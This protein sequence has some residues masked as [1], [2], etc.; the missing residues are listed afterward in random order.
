MFEQMPIP[1]DEYT[2]VILLKICTQLSDPQSFEFSRSLWKKISVNDRKNPVISTSFLHMLL[3]HEEI[4]ICEQFF[5]HIAKD[6]VTFTVMMKGKN[7][8]VLNCKIILFLQGY[9]EHQMPQKA[10]DLFFRIDKPNET[11]AILFFNACAELKDEKTLILA[12]KIFSQ[13]PRRF[14]QSRLLLETIFNTFCRCNDISTA[15][16]LFEQIHRDVIAYGSLMKTYNNQDQSEKTLQLFERMKHE[17]IRAN[18]IIDV[19]VINACANIRFLSLSQSIVRQIPHHLLNNRWIQ[20][21]LIDMWECL[22]SIHND[23][24]VVNLFRVN[25]VHYKKQS[26]FSIRSINQTVSLS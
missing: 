21:S 25:Q 11:N 15:E 4:S 13:L 19:L 3:K 26:E 10:I 17:N 7:F 8:S 20:T 1:P 16:S 12:K 6:N 18:S 24:C 2:Y 23:Q 9:L 14:H 5:S 22:Y